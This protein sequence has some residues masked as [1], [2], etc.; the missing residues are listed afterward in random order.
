MPRRAGR[1]AARMR[2][3]APLLNA[4]SYS[5]S[6]SLLEPRKRV[7]DALAP[8]P[9]VLYDEGTFASSLLHTARFG[10]LA[11]PIEWEVACVS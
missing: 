9:L 4:G 7:V 3:P 11:V 2:L 5:L 10:Q 8:F 1:Y 6:L